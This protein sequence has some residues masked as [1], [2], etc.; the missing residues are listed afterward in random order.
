MRKNFFFQIF[1]LCFVIGS[2]SWLSTASDLPIPSPSATSSPYAIRVTETPTVTHTVTL[3]PTPKITAAVIEEIRINDLAINENNAGSIVNLSTFGTSSDSCLISPDIDTALEVRIIDG[4]PQY[5]LAIKELESQSISIWD[6]EAEKV[7][8]TF[9]DLDIDSIF[10]HP[11]KNTLISFANREKSVISFWDIASGDL[12]NEFVL[13]RKNIYYD[14][15]LSFSKNGLRTSTFTGY[16]NALDIRVSEFDF[17]SAT[18]ESQDYSFALYSEEGPTATQ[19]YSP[20]GNLVAVVNGIDNKLH[21][22]DFTNSKDILLE[23][24][25]QNYDEIISAGAEFSKAAI[26][27]DETYIVAGALSGEIYVWNTEDGSLLTILKAH[28]TRGVDGW[29][30]GIK[31]LEFSPAANVLLSVGY[32]GSTKLWTIPSGVLL[33]EINTCHHF[34]GFTQDG[35]YLITMGKNGIEKWGLP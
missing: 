17:Q 5:L 2:C 12:R 34:G 4:T 18:L 13:D 6:I 15:Y 35:R 26:N 29:G 11:D 16:G 9:D 30:G 19:F 8:Q 31:N 22:L 32:D 21:F 3:S 23:Y 28:K 33:K 25:F 20:N 7:I 1:A 14:D 10:F 27:W 24:T